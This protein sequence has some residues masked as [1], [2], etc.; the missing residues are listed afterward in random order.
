MLAQSVDKV[1]IVE[2]LCC[3]KATLVRYDRYGAANRRACMDMVR[4]EPKAS[5]R[6]GRV[7][8]DLVA[9]PAWRI[10]G[11]RHDCQEYAR[12]SQAVPRRDYSQGAEVL[13]ARR[14]AAKGRSIAVRD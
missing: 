12:K 3:A 13:C 5:G 11:G 4:G 7:G 6:I 14:G 1:E 9:W 10:S 8:S 2:I